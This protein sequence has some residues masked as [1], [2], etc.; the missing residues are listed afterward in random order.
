[1]KGSL[2]LSLFPFLLRTFRFNSVA[3]FQS[4]HHEVPPREAPF[5]ILTRGLLNLLPGIW[6]TLTKTLIKG[7]HAGS[8]G[9]SCLSLVAV[10]AAFSVG[11]GKGLRVILCL[12]VSTIPWHIGVP[13]FHVPAPSL[14]FPYIPLRWRANLYA[15]IDWDCSQSKRSWQS[16]ARVAF[17]RKIRPWGSQHESSEALKCFFWNQPF[18]HIICY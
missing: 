18:L 7:K 13:S 3:W 4:F 14:L 2:S 5:C 11:K 10:V 1:M 17:E 12:R 6:R 15:F 8:G 16:K 9:Q